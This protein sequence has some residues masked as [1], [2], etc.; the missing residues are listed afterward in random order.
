MTGDGVNDAPA[1]K[2]A[3]AGIALYQ[4]TDAVKSAADIVL[5]IPG[6]SVIINAIKKVT[7]YF[8]V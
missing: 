7:E 4:A 8:V 3:D 6:F 1:L 2:E 5:T